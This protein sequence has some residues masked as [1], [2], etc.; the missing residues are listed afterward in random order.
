MIFAV[1]DRVRYNLLRPESTLPQWRG[2]TWR[3]A[4]LTGDLF[5]RLENDNGDIQDRISTAMLVPVT[6]DLGGRNY[7]VAIGCP[8]CGNAGAALLPPLG[9]R[10]EYRCPHCGDFSIDGSTARLFELGTHD[11]NLA[12]TGRR[13]LRP[14]PGTIM[15]IGFRLEPDG[16]VLCQLCHGIV[17]SQLDAVPRCAQC[18]GSYCAACLANGNPQLQCYGGHTDPT[19]CAL[20]LPAARLQPKREPEVK[21]PALRAV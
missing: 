19:H 18:G 13:W 11:I 7:P 8:R 15:P 9:D 14:L 2:T 6:D 4:A 21:P 12:R 1:G 5:A 3:I 10:S 17:A 20:Q 16:R